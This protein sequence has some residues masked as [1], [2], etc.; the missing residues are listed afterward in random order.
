MDSKEDTIGD[1]VTE[2]EE[3]KAGKVIQQILKLL[4]KHK[5]TIP[6][7]IIVYGNLGYHIGAS[8]AGLQGTGPSIEELKQIYYKNPTIDIG[9]MLQGLLI[10]SWEEDFQ[11]QPRISDIAETYIEKKEKKE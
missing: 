6:Q 8:I 4:N 9:L 2:K 7:M 11:K 3:K 5:L 10:T 1:I